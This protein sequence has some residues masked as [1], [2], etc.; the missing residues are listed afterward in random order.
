MS[1][2]FRFEYS[3]NARLYLLEKFGGFTWGWEARQ[4]PSGTSQR[5]R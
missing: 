1:N 4:V 3:K 2:I 5:L